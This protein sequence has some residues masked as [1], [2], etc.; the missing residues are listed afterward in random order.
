MNGDLTTWLNST[1]KPKS[2]GLDGNPGA[3]ALDPQGG[4][5]DLQGGCP[6]LCCFGLSGRMAEF[7]FA[8]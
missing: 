6:G 2:R 1:N 3:S 7:D 4:A 8:S 5:S